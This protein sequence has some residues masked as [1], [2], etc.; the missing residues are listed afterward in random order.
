MTE[1]ERNAF[2]HWVKEKWLLGTP[3]R[4]LTSIGKTGNDSR[5]VL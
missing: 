2:E 5:A 4:S 3:Y 1:A